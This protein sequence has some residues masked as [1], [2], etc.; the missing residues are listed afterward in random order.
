MDIV[1][2]CDEMLLGA[3]ATGATAAIG[4]TYNVI[5][6]LYLRLIEAFHQNDMETAR[7]KQMQ[8]VA[9]IRTLNQY[10]FHPAMKEVLRMLG[11]DVGCCRLPHR[12]LTGDEIESLRV[13]LRDLELFKELEV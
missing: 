7:A 8:S 10:P 11:I 2:G 13:D 9:F 4:S 6:P 3:L 1:F 12:V 5:A